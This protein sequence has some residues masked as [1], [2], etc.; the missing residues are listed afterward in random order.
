M[1]AARFLWLWL[2]FAWGL[3]AV[4]SYSPSRYYVLFYPAMAGLAMSSD[5]EQMPIA[6]LE[7]MSTELPVVSTDVGDVKEMVSEPNRRWV[8]P[9]GDDEA[10]TAVL[11]Q[12]CENR[13]DR[14]RLGQANRE[15]CLRDYDLRNMIQ[16][17]LKLYSEALQV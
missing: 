4:V 5:T 6:V 9:L 7:A 16:A 1:E 11:A 12:L 8:T 3:L 13:G 14:V 2:L 17:Y 15:K 10:Y